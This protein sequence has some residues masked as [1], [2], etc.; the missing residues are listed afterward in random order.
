MDATAGKEVATLPGEKGCALPAD[1]AACHALI[2]QL[3][4]Q[5]R[6]KDRLIDGM[7]HQLKQLLH[8]LYGR[9]SE[10]VD[11]NQLALFAEMLQQLQSSETQPAPTPVVP[12]PAPTGKPSSNG[13]GRRRLPADLPRER[14]VIDLPDNEKPCPLCGEM[15]ETIGEEVSEKL[16]YVP[17]QLRV[18]QTVRPKYACKP[19]DA[20]GHGAQIA[21]AELPASP[22]EK[23]LAAPGLLAAV[24]VGKYSDHL[25]LN[26]LERIFARHDIDLS[27]LLYDVE[28]QAHEQFA[29][30]EHNESALSLAAIR[31][32][33]RQTLSVPRLAQFKA[34]LESQQASR[35]G[36]VLP[37]SPMGQAITYALNQWEALCVYCTDGELDIDNN[38]SERTL[39]RIAVGRGNWMFCGSDNGGN[40]AAILFSFIATCERHRVNPFEYLRDVLTRLASTPISQLADLLP[41]RWKPASAI[42]PTVPA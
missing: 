39:R 36:P 23:G 26:R 41:G 5:Q 9:S 21:L 17:A 13:H 7:Q 37:K 4:E 31:Q 28:S 1:L 12:T 6:E 3:L 8:R 40:T 20:A 10:K 33:L 24:I 18:L 42:S 25:P 38:V 30:Q 34:W 15:R 19:C 35:G 11:P 14:K 29:A 22:I 32:D 27:R 2:A 16:D